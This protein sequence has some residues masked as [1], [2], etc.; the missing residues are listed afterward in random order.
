[1]KTEDEMYLFVSNLF[2]EL[3]DKEESEGTASL[4]EVEDTV[5]QIWLLSWKRPWLR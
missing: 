3:V 2:D 4:S 1:M 5:V